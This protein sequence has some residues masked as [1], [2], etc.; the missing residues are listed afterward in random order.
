MTSIMEPSPLF[1]RIRAI[2]FTCIMMFSFLWLILLCVEM[3]TRWSI[4]DPISQSLMIL[5]ILTNTTTLIMLPILILVPFRMW[6]DKARLLLLFVLQVG[7]AVAGSVWGPKIQCP[8]QTPDDLGICQ[9]ISVYTMI[10]CWIIPTIFGF[11]S[12]YFAVVVCLQ[13]R[14]PVAVGPMLYKRRSGVDLES[15]STDSLSSWNEKI[16]KFFVAHGSNTDTSVSPR[17]LVLPTLIHARQASLPQHQSSLPNVPPRQ[18]T[19]PSLPHTGQ[20]PPRPLPP[21]PS[22]HYSLPAFKHDNGPHLRSPTHVIHATP[23]RHQCIFIPS[24]YTLFIPIPILTLLSCAPSESILQLR[25]YGCT[26]SQRSPRDLEPSL[27]DALVF[28]SGRDARR[29]REFHDTPHASETVEATSRSFVVAL[30]C[31][32][33]SWY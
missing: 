17:P 2:T 30:K 24:S 33:C 19:M 23:S 10:A 15:G 26:V 3:F 25:C 7:S 6:L 13:S 4:S 8:N 5:F 14:T 11:Y 12:T 16:K 21:V 22:R 9:L 28:L 32:A 29:R 1:F 31:I 18:S 27:N 20:R